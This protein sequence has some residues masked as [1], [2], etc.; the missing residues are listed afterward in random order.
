MTS[1][2]GLN[3]TEEK[4]LKKKNGDL[5]CTETTRRVVRQE[6]DPASDDEGNG[7]AM[8]RSKSREALM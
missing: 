3:L 1:K 4:K 8:N 6:E 5:G 7:C 2:L